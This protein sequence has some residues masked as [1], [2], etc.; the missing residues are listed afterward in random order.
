[1]KHVTRLVIVALTVTVA[2]LSLDARGVP[3]TG[4]VIDASTREPVRGAIVTAGA[5]QTQTDEHGTFRLAVAPDGRI[6]VRAHGYARI[7]VTVGSLTPSSEVALTL[8]QPK[9]L[10]LSVFGVANRALRDAALELIDT[11][12]LNALVIDVKGDRGIIG[13]RSAIP[14]AEQIGAQRVITMPDLA[15]LVASLR[16]R[17]IYTIARIVVFKDDPLA[18]AR[19]DLAIRR[20]NGTAYRDR[21]NLSWTD[22]RK[23]DVRR[24]N[25][26]VAREAAQA[27]FDEIQF[28]YVRFPDAQGLAYDVP[29]TQTSRIDAIDGFLREAREVLAAYNVFVSIDI[30]GYVCWNPNDTGIGQ[31]LERMAETVD[32]ISPMLYPSSFQFGIPGYRNPVQHPYE[33]VRLSLERAVERTGLPP[34]RFRPWLQA[35]AD[36]A[37]GGRSFNAGEIR[38]QIA[39]AEDVGTNGW[40]LWNPRNRYSSADLDE[41][42]EPIR[43]GPAGPVGA[44]SLTPLYR[45][46][47]RRRQ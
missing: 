46:A 37:F 24:Y 13:H 30:F 16:Q 7:E 35:F 44:T 22:P 23:T 34:V 29:D 47:G 33:I 10:Y 28:D 3:I 9:A 43:P 14:L 36:Y 4:V 27:G 38:A 15:E 42:G 8:L 40:M 6:R 20:P 12:E 18:S 11:T 31:Q 39:A 1:M 32:Y 2:S 26:E 17:G 45:K 5:L 19:P 41:G 21:E 25:I